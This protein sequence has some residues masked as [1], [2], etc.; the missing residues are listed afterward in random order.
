MKLL[1]SCRKA[2]TMLELVFVIAILGIVASIS[3]SVIVQ[4]YESYIMQRA[5]HDASIDTELAINQL[6]NRLTYRINNSLLARTPGQTGL[7]DADALPI[8][9]LIT[10][11]QLNTYTALEWINYD[12]DAF[13]G[14]NPPAWSGFCDLN[15]S[16]YNKIITTGSKLT[17]L[18]SGASYALV[19]LGNHDYRIN[20]GAY[21]DKRCMY[22]NNGCI[23]P[24]TITDD[25]TL[26]FNGGNRA[27]HQ[28]LYTEFYQLA[29][30]AYSVV[31][32]NAHSINSINV[33]D[34]RLYSNYQPWT[35]ENYKDHGTQTTL[36]KNVSTFRFKEEANSLR[37]KICQVVPIGDTSQVTI[38]KEK[39]VI[40]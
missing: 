21:S 14:Y 32:E 38:C 34:L 24:M 37:I 11:I 13:A 20:G 28:M 5:V 16:D 35:N 29:K 31:P 40:R 22:S 2:F 15:A 25:T 18:D 9:E 33:W 12:H 39:A 36:I 8:A 3:S 17:N 7:T 26:T 27:Q 19:F 23:F 4:V 30:T 1:T 6:A 10:E